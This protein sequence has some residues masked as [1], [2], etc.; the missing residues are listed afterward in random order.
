MIGAEYAGEFGEPAGYLD[1]ARF[2]PPSRTVTETT[3]R[4]LAGSA[5]AGP[6][7]VDDLMR[8][9]ARAKAAV[10][11]L[12]RTDTDHVVLVPNTSQ[13][14]FQAAFAARGEVLVPVSEFPANT[15]PWARAEEAGLLKP[16][17]MRPPKGHVTADAVAAELTASITLVSVS[18]VDFRT[19]YR[20]DLAALRET[21]GALARSRPAEQGITVSA[22]PA[23]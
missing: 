5:R 8:H 18:A 3:A 19:G 13:G 10:A 23:R 9:E 17:S 6:S 11:R 12:C 2:G 21:A 22:H 15:V 20:A 1:F 16:R 14:L 4:L 7:T